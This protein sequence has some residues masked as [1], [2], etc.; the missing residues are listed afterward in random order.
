MGLLALGP[1]AQPLAGH[2]V[3]D[4]YLRPEPVHSV[5]VQTVDLPRTQPDLSAELD[6]RPPVRPDGF[7][8]HIESLGF[9]V[10]EELDSPGLDLRQLQVVERVH[11]H[12]RRVLPHR[13][14]V[15]LAHD[16]DHVVD[17]GRADDWHVLVARLDRPALVPGPPRTL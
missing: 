16:V 4:L 13:R 6:Q 9:L 7:R 12:D 3:D 1:L 10:L 11:E 14:G 8:R 5:P 2:H 15:Q 17:G